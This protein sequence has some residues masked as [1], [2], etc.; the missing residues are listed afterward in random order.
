[1]N[2]CGADAAESA[3]QNQRNHILQ[4]LSGAAPPQRRADLCEELSETGC[5]TNGSL[6]A[7]R[8]VVG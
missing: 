4:S 7:L 1:M 2:R 8:R 6:V 3:E 5:E